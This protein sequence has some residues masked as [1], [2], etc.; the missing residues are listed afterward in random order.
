MGNYFIQP[1]VLGDRTERCERCGAS[2]SDI[3]TGDAQRHCTPADLLPTAARARGLERRKFGCGCWGDVA[4]GTPA[5]NT[6]VCANCIFGHCRAMLDDIRR[7]GAVAKGPRHLSMKELLVSARY[8]VA[9]VP[10]V[11]KVCDCGAVKA[12]TTHSHWCTTQS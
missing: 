1:H 8:P 7:D 10:V 6:M 3:S 5:A 9:A 12:R 11:A 4:V 2:A